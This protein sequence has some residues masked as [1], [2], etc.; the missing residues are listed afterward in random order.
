[1]N[2]SSTFDAPFYVFIEASK[3]QIPRVLK[4]LTLNEWTALELNNFDSLIDSNNRHFFL[5][6]KGNWIH[7][8]D[9]WNYTLWFDSEFIS[10]LT[11][12]SSDF[13]IFTCSIGDS[14]NSFDFRLFRKGRITREY[15]VEDPNHDGGHIAKNIGEPL[16]GE[17]E[18]LK[19]VDITD[20]VLS[21]A[22]NLGIDIVHET[23][24]ITAFSREEREDEKFEFDESEY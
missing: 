9:D 24:K 15:V 6:T 12:L 2:D 14:D 20:R 19:K 5:T 1:M 4:E 10:R 23:N 7:I 18:A 13:K 8:M 21:I 17:R 3:E 16:D 11:K 22:S